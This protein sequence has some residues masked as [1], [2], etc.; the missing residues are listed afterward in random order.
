[1][2]TTSYFA[3]TLIASDL[4]GKTLS[5]P[6][7]Q[8]GDYLTGPDLSL[9]LQ[10]QADA[11]PTL[12]GTQWARGSANATISLS[13]GTATD[14]AT[15]QE[16]QLALLA[17]AETWQG[18]RDGVAYLSTTDIDGVEHVTTYKAT[19]SSVQPSVEHMRNR[20]TIDYDLTLYPSTTSADA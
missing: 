6:I 15:P 7:V 10:L 8:V 13:V 14:Y 1:M 11:S 5:L 2:R 20:L 9:N 17:V 18:I 3:L 4:T 19:V 12:T 16:A